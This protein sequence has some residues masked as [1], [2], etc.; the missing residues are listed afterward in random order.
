MHVCVNVYVYMCAHCISCSTMQLIVYI[1]SVKSAWQTTLVR[2]SE[3]SCEVEATWS[4]IVLQ[5]DRF[6]PLLFLQA[7]FANIVAERCK[8]VI[9][10]ARDRRRGYLNI[11]GK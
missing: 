4:A 10:C 3:C 8:K 11:L 9:C 2:C 1:D 6:K 5:L 7:D